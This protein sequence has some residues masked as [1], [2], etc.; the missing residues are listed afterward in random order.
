M[1][2]DA[3][4]EID[5]RR[6]DCAWEETPIQT[7]GAERERLIDALPYEAPRRTD[8]ATPPAYARDRRILKD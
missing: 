8:R 3:A 6:C 1:I 7:V 4:A 2:P 5:L